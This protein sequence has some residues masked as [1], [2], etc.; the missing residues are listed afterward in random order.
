MIA[1]RLAPILTLI[2]VVLLSSIHHGEAI[3]CYQATANTIQD[4]EIQF[5]PYS[6]GTVNCSFQPRLEHLS[7]LEPTLCRKISQKV[8]REDQGCQRLRIHYGRKRQWHV[9]EEI[10]YSRCSGTLLLMH[11]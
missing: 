7:H 4:V 2:L 6:L 3:I 9:L 11:R 5:D 10:R 8:L 1:N